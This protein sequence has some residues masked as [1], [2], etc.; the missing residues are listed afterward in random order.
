MATV[1]ER[2]VHHTDAGT[3]TSA[4]TLIVAILAIVL[5]GG[6]ALYA[7]QVFP[8]A[9]NNAGGGSMNIDVNTPVVPDPTPTPTPVQ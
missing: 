3:D 4:V 8:F 7:L 9:N 1:I 5:I 2:D 6:L